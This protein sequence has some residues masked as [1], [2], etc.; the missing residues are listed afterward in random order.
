[1]VEY[2]NS[3]NESLH[4]SHGP[5]HNIFCLGEFAMT[6]SKLN[7]PALSKPTIPTFVD[8][9]GQRF[10]MLVALRYIGRRVKRSGAMWLC[11]CD[12]GKQSTVS[13]VDLRKPSGGSKSCGCVHTRHGETSGGKIS[14][15]YAAFQAAQARCTSRRRREWRWYGARGIKFLYTSFEEFLN[16]VGRRPTAQHTLD[17]KNSRGHYEPG[18]CHWATWK[19]QGNNR[20]NNYNITIDGQTLSISEWSRRVGLH[21]STIFNRIYQSGWCDQCAVVLPRRS[22]CLHINKS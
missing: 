4:L 5:D 2:R 3:P 15:E 20:T 13:G 21:N 10:G 11:Q 22:H 1:M 14:P 18:N 16:D 6:I 8:I 17:R 19:D 9:E 7:I 12:C